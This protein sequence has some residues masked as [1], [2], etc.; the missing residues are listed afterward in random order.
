MG[1]SMAFWDGDFAFKISVEFADHMFLV[2]VTETERL[3]RLRKM[4]ENR[5]PQALAQLVLK[6]LDWFESE[7]LFFFSSSCLTSICN[8]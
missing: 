4:F 1:N 7:K 5:D 6:N 3:D 8:P 2:E